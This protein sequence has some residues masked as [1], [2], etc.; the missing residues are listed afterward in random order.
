MELAWQTLEKFKVGSVFIKVLKNLIFFNLL[1][2]PKQGAKAGRSFNGNLP[3]LS[4][5]WDQLAG[6]I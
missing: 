2:L 5:I 6:K 4:R 1:V 3:W